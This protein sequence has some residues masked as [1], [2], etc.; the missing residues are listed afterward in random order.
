MFFEMCMENKLFY[1]NLY[2]V[3]DDVIVIKNQ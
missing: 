3:K 1:N 2:I